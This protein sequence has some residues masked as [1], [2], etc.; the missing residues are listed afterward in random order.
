M[1]DLGCNVQFVE[2]V[3]KTFF[4]YWCQMDFLYW[5][6]SQTI[7]FYDVICTVIKVLELVGLFPTFN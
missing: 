3:L 7:Y 4:T 5:L 1:K 6:V 2:K